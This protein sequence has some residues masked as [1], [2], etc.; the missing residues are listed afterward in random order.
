[1]EDSRKIS[2]FKFRDRED[3]FIIVTEKERNVPENVQPLV[4]GGI[5]LTDIPQFSGLLK[6]KNYDFVSS[7]GLANQVSGINSQGA[8]RM[9]EEERGE[10]DLKLKFKRQLQQIKEMGIDD[11]GMILQA[12]LQTNGNVQL[13]IQKLMQ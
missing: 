13:A 4:V 11:E 5:D 1:M 12:L 9:Q 10:V 7:A 6:K 3:I 8:P 2:E